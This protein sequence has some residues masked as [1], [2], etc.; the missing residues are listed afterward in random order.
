MNYIETIMTAI[1]SGAIKLPKGGVLSP[2]I[3]HDSWC[4][5]NKGKKECNC[6]PDI[7]VET[8]EGLIFLNKDGS[9]KKTI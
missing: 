6:N 3:S 4:K 2:T 9:V 5:I 1:G 8:D 7:S